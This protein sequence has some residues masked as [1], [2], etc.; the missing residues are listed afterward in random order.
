MKY[1]GDSYIWK[2]FGNLLVPI[3]SLSNMFVHFLFLLL[4]FLSLVSALV[5]SLKQQVGEKHRPGGEET[6][7]RKIRKYSSKLF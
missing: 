3:C 1:F 2:I 4:T 6:L 7:I 5:W